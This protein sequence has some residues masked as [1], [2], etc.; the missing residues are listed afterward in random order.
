MKANY[1]INQVWQERGNRSSADY[2]LTEVSHDQL[3]DRIRTLAADKRCALHVY[4][5]PEEWLERA[6]DYDVDDSDF[7]VS[8][9]FSADGEFEEDGVRYLTRKY[10]CSLGNADYDDIEVVVDCERL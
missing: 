2:N 9:K 8:F 10:S 5:I 3:M 6:C 4:R 7:E 1:R